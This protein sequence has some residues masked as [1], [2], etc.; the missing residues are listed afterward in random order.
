MLGLAAPTWAVP[1]STTL[2]GEITEIVDPALALDLA[3]GTPATMT[4]TWDTDDLY[5]IGA[6]R[7]EAGVLSDPNGGQSQRDAHRHRRFTYLGR[8]GRMSIPTNLSRS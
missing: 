6:R 3:V 7:F 2:V 8:S 5:D 4:A 1:M